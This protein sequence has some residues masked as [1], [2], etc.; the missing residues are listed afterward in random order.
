MMSREDKIE[1]RKQKAEI[2]SNLKHSALT[3]VMD[4]K[5]ESCIITDN[6]LLNDSIQNSERQGG[7][8][9]TVGLKN[10]VMVGTSAPKPAVLIQKDFNNN[11]GYKDLYDHLNNPEAKAF[12][13]CLFSTAYA[14]VF[15]GKQISVVLSSSAKTI[16]AP[17]EVPADWQH[18]AKHSRNCRV[19]EKAGIA[20]AIITKTILFQ[21]NACPKNRQDNKTKTTKIN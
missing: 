10:V 4:Y 17:P 16:G 21:I 6:A 20:S 9:D 19:D 15:F 5:P 11:I 8:D 12:N 1:E 13:R 7:T 2:H 18:D 14:N 3:Q